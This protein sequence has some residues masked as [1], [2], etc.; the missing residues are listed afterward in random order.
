MCQ[1]KKKRKQL[2]ELLENENN[3]LFLSKSFS[4]IKTTFVAASHLVETNG[5]LQSIILLN[6]KYVTIEYN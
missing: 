1:K 2:I 5:L 3:W 6:C 4:F